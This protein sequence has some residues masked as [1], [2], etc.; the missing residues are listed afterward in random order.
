MRGCF[1]FVV[2]LAVLGAVGVFVYINHDKITN[3]L[4]RHT[5]AEKRAAVE[6]GPSKK[7]ANA[8]AAKLAALQSGERHSVAFSE[9]E[10]QSLLQYKYRG[11]LPAFVIDP[12]VQIIRNHLQISGRMPLKRLPDLMNLGQAASFLPDTTEV[13]VNGELLPWRS[14]RVAL[15][16]DGVKVTH[17]PLPHRF[18]ASSLKQLGRKSEPGLPA[19]A[20]AVNLP[21]GVYAAYVRN[22]SLMFLRR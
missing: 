17:I 5:G 13:A 20:I 7:L 1:R 19:E 10:L 2:M 21:A 11:L 3:M 14:G 9:D 18:I 16:V 12:H 6:S 15:M 4:H 22:D 8:A